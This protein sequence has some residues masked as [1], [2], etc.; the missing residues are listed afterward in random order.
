[1]EI[2]DFYRLSLP[3][4]KSLSI[5]SGKLAQNRRVPEVIH[6]FAHIS[7]V[8]D[9]YIY[10]YDDVRKVL[11]R[12]LLRSR[13]VSL[14]VSDATKNQLQTKMPRS[15][16]LASI[17]GLKSKQN[18][19][20]VISSSGKYSKKQVHSCYDASKMPKPLRCRAFLHPNIIKLLL[21]RA[22]RHPS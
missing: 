13:E 7:H 11:V 1:M 20:T 9:I 8:P 5:S 10:I 18:H 4:K 16:A 2:S 6:G 22:F 15:S 17:Q 3:F 14:Y 19:R 21:C 12:A